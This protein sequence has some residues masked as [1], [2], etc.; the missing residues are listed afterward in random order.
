MVKIGRIS[1]VQFVHDATTRLPGVTVVAYDK[2]PDVGGT[3]YEN[4]YPGYPKP[5]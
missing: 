3:W 5:P 1:G 4:R 2:N